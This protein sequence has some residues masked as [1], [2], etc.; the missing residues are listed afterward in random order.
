M[1]QISNNGFAIIKYHNVSE[2]YAQIEALV[3]QP[4]H[5]IR[6]DEMEKYLEGFDKKYAS[7]KPVIE[8]ARKYIPG[9]VQHNLAF[10]YPFPIVF[11]RTE[12]AYLYDKDG[13][14]HIDFLQA[15]G[16]TILG[17]N[18]PVPCAT[19]SAFAAARASWAV[20]AART[21]WTATLAPRVPTML[22][23]V[24]PTSP[25]VLLPV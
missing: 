16:P 9:G 23:A 25:A 2:I 24:S 8:E 3:N 17:S 15:G 14:R 1:N 13:N 22:M 7:S 21:H 10:N 5:P 18:P 12:G 4:I 6:R 20:L 11:D 19:F